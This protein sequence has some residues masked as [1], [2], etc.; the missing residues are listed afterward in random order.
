MNLIKAKP[1][2]PSQ[3]N[4]IQ[5]KSSILSKTP[6]LK[7]EIK[8]VKTRSGKNSSGV[9]TVRH[10]GGG[11]KQKYRKIEFTRNKTATEIITSIEYDPNRNSF[12]ASSYNF[13]LQTYHY[14]ISPKNINIGD[15]IESG[16]NA[17]IKVG[18]S[19]P[20][21]KIP[22]GSLIHNVSVNSRNYAQLSRSAGTFSRLV[23]KTSKYGIII[24]SSG[25]QYL[26]PINCFATLGVV[27][28]EFSFLT[29]KSKAGRSRWLNIRP[30]VRG[31]A[32]NPIDHPHGG[33]EGKT[34]GGRS[35]VTPWGR[36]TKNGKT[37]YL[38]NKQI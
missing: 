14:I 26:I 2:T 22:I 8:G 29:T 18:H 34:S 30:S 31:V 9:I 38:K 24:L 37:S 17:K 27:S 35:S 5:I 19:L 36:P 6:L 16:S 1:I 10:K 20:L 28:N 32:M 13:Q 7:K 23:K 11:H 4:L 21:S 25:N 15:I 3:R 12:I 33:G